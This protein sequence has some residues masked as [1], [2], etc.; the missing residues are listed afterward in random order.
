MIKY[1]YQGSCDSLDMDDY[2]EVDY[3][4]LT[5][6]IILAILENPEL[7]D[8]VNLDRI[9]SIISAGKY[10][11]IKRVDSFTYEMISDIVKE[12]TDADIAF[13]LDSSDETKAV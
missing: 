13:D 7:K 1:S 5:A 6:A 9:S 2:D 11:A 10:G 12:H 3:E 4:A 8:A